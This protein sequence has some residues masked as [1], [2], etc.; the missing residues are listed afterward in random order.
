MT[1]PNIWTVYEDVHFRVE[2]CQTCPIPGYL[3]L[4]A[5][6]KAHSLDELSREALSLLGLGRERIVRVPVDGQG[7]PYASDHRDHT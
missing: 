5:K 1:P 4:Y 6:A 3:I 2:Q 7:R